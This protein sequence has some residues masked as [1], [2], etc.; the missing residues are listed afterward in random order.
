M[1][2]L[3]LLVET[4]SSKCVILCVLVLVSFTMFLYLIFLFRPGVPP[5]MNRGGQFMNAGP[6]AGGQRPPNNN[7]YAT[8][9]GQ[10]VMPP[11]VSQPGPNNGVVGPNPTP[12]QPGQSMFAPGGQ[13][14]TGGPPPQGQAVNA[15]P[16]PPPQGGGGGPIPPSQP[17]GAPPGW[18]QGANRNQG[19]GQPPNRPPVPGMGQLSQQAGVAMNGQTQPPQQ[20]QPQGPQSQPPQ[21]ANYVEFDHAINYVTT[22]KKRFQHEQRTYQQFL[23]ILHTYQKEQRGIRE[24][25][26]QV[27]AL[28]ADHPDLLKEFTH[29]LPEA[30]QEQAKERLHRAAAEAEARIHAARQQQQQQGIDPSQISSYQQQQQQQQQGNFP[31]RQ[32]EVAAPNKV[33]STSV[34]PGQGDV[35]A[36][37]QQKYMIDMTNKVR[38]PKGLFNTAHIWCV[39]R[40]TIF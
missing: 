38:F 32:V 27:S 16:Q 11:Q 12:N 31:V 24:V 20:V 21:G 3:H 18:N 36:D 9:Q 6:G 29:F 33:P 22:I 10:M 26:N 39:R 2:V 4:L 1:L 19:M 7:M 14:G 5:G 40:T 15:G 17:N 25:L 23:E 30:V 37:V 34:R 35:S 8:A 28:F 13:R